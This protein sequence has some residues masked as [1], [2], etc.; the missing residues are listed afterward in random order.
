YEIETLLEFRRVLFRSKPTAPHERIA[1]NDT[2]TSFALRCAMLS[3]SGSIGATKK[4]NMITVIK[5]AIN[6][7]IEKNIIPVINNIN[8]H[9]TIIRLTVLNL[10]L[11]NPQ[12]GCEKI[13]ANGPIA[14]MYPISVPFN[15]LY[16]KNNGK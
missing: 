2:P 6:P 1:P 8:V 9:K 4:T 11:I 5:N 15:P 7:F 13:E 12:K 3:L 10:S 14:S 16:F